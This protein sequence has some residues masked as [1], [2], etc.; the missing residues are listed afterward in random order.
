MP[1]EYAVLHEGRMIVEQ[2]VGALSYEALVEHKSRQR[3]DPR[4]NAP[5]SVLSDCR[6]ATV[7]IAPEAIDQLSAKEHDHQ[8]QAVQR[9]A[10]LV[11]PDVYERVQR[12]GAGVAPIG[13]SV[14]IFNHLDS[15][16]RWLE[17]DPAEIK[18]LIASLGTQA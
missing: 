13:K 9:Y 4:I 15:A 7:D 3:L 18:A 6:L 17:L 16:C 12:F 5:A 8:G 10:F 1:C 2:W 14:R 11:K